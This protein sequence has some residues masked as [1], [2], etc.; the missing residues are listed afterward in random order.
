MHVHIAGLGVAAGADAGAD[1]GA[2]A[3]ADADSLRRLAH[4]NIS[5]EATVECFRLY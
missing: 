1:S 3:G 5:W 2:D 4:R